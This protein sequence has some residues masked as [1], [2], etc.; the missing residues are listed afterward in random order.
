[1]I[2]VQEMTFHSKY[3]SRKKVPTSKFKVHKCSRI[4]PTI[5][6]LFSVEPTLEFPSFFSST[7]LVNR[8][9]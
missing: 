5:T 8:C 9:L 3:I 4:S 6:L 2:I 1:M 7:S